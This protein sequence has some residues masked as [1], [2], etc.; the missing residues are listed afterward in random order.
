M[1][2]RNKFLI[3]VASKAFPGAS[4]KV[5]DIFKKAYDSMR[6]HMSESSAFE[7][8]KR[9]TRSKI[10]IE[11]ESK[12][13]GGLSGGVRK[14]PPPERGPKPQGLEVSTTKSLDYYKDII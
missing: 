12:S 13:L 14:G 9:E 1:S 10:K 6:I 8:A 11:P 5:H 4:K 3:D 7:Q 2:G